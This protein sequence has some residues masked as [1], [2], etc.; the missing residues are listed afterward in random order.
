MDKTA[1]RKGNRVVKE[2]ESKS[3]RA[4]IIC[5]CNKDCATVIDVV[6]QKDIFD[7]FYGLPSWSK[8]TEF[9]RSIVNRESVKENLNPR[10]NLKDRD[11]FST[12]HFFDSD[13][14][15][16]RVCSSFVTKLLQ[17]NRMKLFRG[18]ASI[19]SNPFAIDRRGKGSH[20][21]TAA[22]HTAFAKQFMQ[23]IP[24]YESKID[25]NSFDTK[26]LHPNL[27]LNTIY[28]LYGNMCDFKQKQKLSKSVFVKC[29]KTNYPHLQAF[30][31]EKSKCS[32]CQNN[33]EKKKVKVLAPTTLEN[34]EK[35]QDDHLME[36]RELK[37]E[38]ISSINEPEVGVEIF[39]FEMQRPL[40][41]PLLPIEESYDLRCLWLSNFCIYDEFDKKANMYVWDETTAKRGPEEI[42]SCLFKHIADVISKTTKKVILYSDTLDLYRNI[43][44]PA[45]LGKIFD[46]R[47]DYELETIEQRFFFPGHSSNDC[48]R[49]FD[50]LEKKMKTT[51]SLFT[52]DDWI[53]LISSCKQS[54][55][56]FNVHKM[57]NKDFLSTDAI[58][59]YRTAE[60]VSWADVKGVTLIRSEPLNIRAKYF[61]QNTE[62][63]IPLYKSNCGEMLIYKNANGL[64]I[65]KRKY[66]DLIAK[67]LKSLPAEKRLYYENIQ[68]DA[69]LQDNDLALA[70]YRL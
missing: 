69:N 54:N 5:I 18:A 17:I 52:P 53:E 23:T 38:L 31:P 60:E 42:A 65:S 13:G 15:K 3:F 59:S 26:Y 40:Q 64:A 20:R 61:S 7:Q 27:T 70:S 16:Q 34:I 6:N 9:L 49:C 41:L 37:N 33:D 48:N 12:Y 21:K 68:H 32:I 25:S 24:C 36:L 14:K 45:M 46:Y 22:E 35:Q 8:K 43:Q 63:I 39:V 1:K 62:Q 51:Q 29:F 2:K 56:N 58:M 19:K 55:Q 30:K 47:N 66:D 10:I 67:T 28:R 44:I 57:S 50:T 11:F 4:Q